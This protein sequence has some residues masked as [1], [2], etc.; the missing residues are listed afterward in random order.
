MSVERWA[1]PYCPDSVAFLAAFEDGREIL[2]LG[3][4]PKQ[5]ITL[6]RIGHGLP[7]LFREAIVEDEARGVA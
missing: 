3:T 5:V 2:V 6:Y 7:P 1:D 4:R